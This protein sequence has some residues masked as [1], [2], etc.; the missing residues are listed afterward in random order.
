M[1][2]VKEIQGNKGGTLK[3]STMCDLKKDSGY[4]GEVSR[5]G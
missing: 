5:N 3:A 4:S 1:A 2:I